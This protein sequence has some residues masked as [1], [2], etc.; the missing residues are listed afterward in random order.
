VTDDPRG[1]T[2]RWVVAGLLLGGALLAS[3]RAAAAV[4]RD[5]EALELLFPAG[6][7]VLLAAALTAAALTTLA[8]LR[9]LALLRGL[10]AGRPPVTRWRPFRVAV[11][12][13]FLGW[14]VFVLLLQP[15]SAY[16]Q[17]LWLGLLAGTWAGLVLIADPLAARLPRRL[18][19]ALNIALL[20]L[21]VF[22]VVGELGLRAWA[23]RS[24][25]PLFAQDESAAQMVQTWRMRP[26]HRHPGF[27]VNAT[28]HFDDTD[29]RPRQPGE[30]RVATIGDSFSAST[31][32]HL[33]HFTTVAERKL[34][35]AVDNFGM[36]AIGPREYE[37]LL[38]RE[39]APLR[40]DVIVVNL[41]MGND[42]DAPLAE[43]GATGLA[44][45]WLDGRRLM[46]ARV[47]A[48]R[49]AL[50]ATTP[51]PTA[52]RQGLLREPGGPPAGVAVRDVTLQE[53]LTLYPS[54]A[55]PLREVP[56]LPDDG[57]HR[58]ATRQAQQICGDRPLPWAALFATLER[59]AAR[60]ARDGIRFAVMLIPAEF[61]VEEAVWN[62]VLRLSPE[63]HLERDQPQRVVTAWLAER[64]IPH[65]DLL[66]KLRA[67]TPLS[68]GR[69]HVYHRNETHFNARGNQATGEELAEFLRPL[70]P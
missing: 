17:Q 18:R 6:L 52:T 64:G 32:P 21:A 51:D 31:V 37:H 60:C 54:L 2:V 49:F 61:Q 53:L 46:L 20:N 59:M 25:S 8:V 4:L 57:Y 26:E 10:P 34:G 55:D 65:L 3:W 23:E 56:V 19:A 29:F 22:S 68:D 16:V 44:R 66:P 28:G 9:H 14:L 42:L 12:T 43:P 58:L 62:E 36:P 63:L 69:L 27:P 35:V 30:R 67:V 45:S 11:Y 50:S 47:A 15:W 48:R 70:L 38:D 13:L 7:P 41:F 24:D 33:L 1:G 5:R 39:V 40:P